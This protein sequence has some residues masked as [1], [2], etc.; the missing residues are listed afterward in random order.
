MIWNFRMAILWLPK[1]QVYFIYIYRLLLIN[2]IHSTHYTQSLSV[3]PLMCMQC[4]AFVFHCYVP[5]D[6]FPVSECVAN[7]SRLNLARNKCRVAFVCEFQLMLIST[8]RGTVVLLLPS[9][10]SSFGS[11][12]SS[13]FFPLLMLLYSNLMADESLWFVSAW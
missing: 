5:G 1:Y 2:G 8:L 11:P 9:T 7:T 4:N 6:G 13:A 10:T 3:S 12:S